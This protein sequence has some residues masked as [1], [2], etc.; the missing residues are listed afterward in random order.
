MSNNDKIIL[1][2]VGGSGADEGE[3]TRRGNLPF[4]LSLSEF[5]AVAIHIVYALYAAAL[6][7]AVPSIL[8]VILA[9]LKRP[10][11]RGSW[12]ESH[13][14]WQIRT[15][16]ITFILGIISAAMAATFILFPVAALL[17]A[18]T[19]CWFAWRVLKGWFAMSREDAIPN[20]DAWL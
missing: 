9:Y 12:L 17:G 19:W 11:I 18:I 14:T 5:D 15:F 3:V 7:S 16:W 6:L 1:G 20:P 13:A 10:E 2:P 8:G 4:K